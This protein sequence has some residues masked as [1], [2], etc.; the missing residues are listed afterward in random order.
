MV[1]RS[2]RPSSCALLCLSR[3]T[4]P[5]KRTT[6]TGTESAR[7]FSCNTSLGPHMNIYTHKHTQTNTPTSIS[8][9]VVK[10][11]Q[12]WPPN[13]TSEPA[14]SARS[15]AC[16]LNITTLPVFAVAIVFIIIVQFDL[17]S[18]IFA[19]CRQK[20]E[21]TNGMHI[22][23][24]NSLT[25]I[26]FR[27]EAALTTPNTTTTLHTQNRDEIRARIQS[28]LNFVGSGK[29]LQSLRS[30]WPCCSDYVYIYMYMFGYIPL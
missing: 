25:Y 29:I 19:K 4:S 26:L 16:S 30:L 7:Y 17:L 1:L 27:R 24:K 21:P 8:K 14:S 13:A 9:T 10:R 11:R 28:A 22:D 6:T 2:R 18:F 12:A 20:C 3:Q 23:I 15:P 5:E